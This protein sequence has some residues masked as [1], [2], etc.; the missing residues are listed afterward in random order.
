MGGGW[1][2]LKNEVGNYEGWEDDQNLQK[3]L[4]I[5]KAEAGFKAE[6][7]NV[8]INVK[9][10]EKTLQFGPNKCKTMLV[11]KPSNHVLDSDLQ[12]DSWSVSYH[13]NVETGDLDLIETFNGPVVMEKTTSQKYLGFVLSSTGDNMVNIKH[14]KT[15]AVG[16]IRQIFNRLESLNLQRYYF[17]CAIIFMNC[18]LRSSILYAAETYYNLSEKELREIERIEEGF[19]RKLL[20]TS[21]GC[22]IIQLYL[23]VGIIP[24]RF[25]IMKMRIMF[26]KDILNENEE[27]LIRKFYELQ[28]KKP[29]KGDWASTCVKD[30][31][32]LGIDLS[33]E[34][35]RNMKRKQFK[36]MLKEKINELAFNYLIEKRGKK[37]SE[38]KFLSLR[39]SDYLLPSTS[40]L[41]ISEKQE[42]FS[43]KN[44]MVQIS[45]N[46][47]QNKNIDKC[48]CG[49]EE[50]M[51]HIYSCK[52]LNKEKYQLSFNLIFTGNIGEQIT[53]FKIF[54]NNMKERERLLNNQKLKNK[55][56]HVIPNG[57]PLYD[58]L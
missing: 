14:I 3:R 37:G 48:V 47:P 41:T 22:P 16:K 35:I 27:S 6:Q 46:F 25:Q 20:K 2:G 42:M 56:F 45:Y 17:E 50:T 44:R 52:L 24:A 53:I 31:H 39:M 1:Q 32:Q 13:D 34:E 15:K 10:A 28:V 12:V 26:L 21:K 49:E 33:T 7:M 57:D 58:Y 36:N 43:I 9:T 29:T 18:M 8:F 4:I 5:M 55:N 23:T 11:G 51:E 40:G 38:I 54:Q 19:L 30:L